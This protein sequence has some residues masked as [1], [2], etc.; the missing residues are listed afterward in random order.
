MRVPRLPAALRPWLPRALPRDP[1]SLPATDLSRL[2]LAE[3]MLLGAMERTERLRTQ[4]L[5]RQQQQQGLQQQQGGKGGEL[6]GG[7]VAASDSATAVVTAGGGGGRQ[8]RL[9]PAA[10][11]RA[12]D[13]T[14]RQRTSTVSRL[15]RDVWRVL[16]GMGLQPMVG[17]EGGEG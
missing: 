8:R 2:G 13:G 6:S 9:L 16:Q 17:G 11:R 7:R 15:Q 5:P 10:L 12:V 4:K 14:S 3:V 1:Q